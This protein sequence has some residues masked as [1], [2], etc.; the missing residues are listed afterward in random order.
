MGFFRNAVG[1]LCI[2]FRKDKELYRLTGAV[3]Y[4]VQNE[5][6]DKQGNETEY[7]S[8]PVVKDEIA[9]TDDNDITEHDHSSESN[10][11]IFINNGC[12][13][14]GT[15]CAAVIIKYHP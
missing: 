4:I 9:W 5:T 14:I 3:D 12:N 15:T 6:D 7:H 1:N 10:V 11:L 2:I 8:A 13:D